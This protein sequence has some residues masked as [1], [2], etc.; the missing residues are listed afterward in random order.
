MPVELWESSMGP[1]TRMTLWNLPLQFPFEGVLCP[2]KC[3]RSA[4]ILA[5]RQ[6][7]QAGQLHRL[8]RHRLIDIFATLL[9]GPRAGACIPWTGTMASNFARTGLEG[10]LPKSALGLS[11][12]ARYRQQR[13]NLWRTSGCAWPELYASDASSC[14]ELYHGIQL[15]LRTSN[16]YLE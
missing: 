2:S 10:G 3:S 1:R 14:V 7:K 12:G 16:S 4:L 15:Q 9:E 8:A 13:L 6:S 5:P 11:F